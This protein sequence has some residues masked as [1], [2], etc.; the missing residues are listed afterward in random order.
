M[1]PPPQ[2]DFQELMNIV[3]GF[4]PAKVLMVATE[5]GLFDALEKPRTAAEAAAKINA[6]SRALEILLNALT[7]MGVVLKE[8][9]AFRNGESAS[10]Y[11]VH[12]K[13]EYR[14]AIVRHTHHTWWGWTEL[15]DT[16]VH[17]HAHLEKTERWLDRVPES[18]REWMQDFIWGMHAL[19]RDLAPQ[20]AALLDFTGVRTLL[21]LG[22][23]PATYAIY[24]A[25]AA[26]KLKATVFDLPG[27]IE[28]ARENIAK[29]GLSHRVDTLTGNFLTDD[30]G[31]P[32][33][34]IW[35]SHILHSHTEE[36]CLDILEKSVKALNPGGTLAFQD[37][38]LND[39][40]CTPPEAAFFSVH[41]LAVTPG[42]RSYKHREV[43]QW[44]TR[45][46]LTTPTHRPTSPQTSILVAKKG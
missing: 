27:P 36:Q 8:G 40:G 32:Y 7:A 37:F 23:G 21:D 15:Q 16:V 11:L 28:I 5:L 26:P 4:R 35:I 39:D 9:E 18:E 12:G 22:G 2:N 41:M 3:R 43:A 1:A 38:F 25:Q 24:F 31:G 19:A 20:V 29:H 14:G 34:F 46:G 33:D 45:A 10:R 13:E 17:G 42:G 44:M 6:D 30:I